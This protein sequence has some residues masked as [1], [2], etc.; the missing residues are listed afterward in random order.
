MQSPSYLGAFALATPPGI[1]IDAS[2]L[3]SHYSKATLAVRLLYRM[4]LPLAFPLP[5]LLYCFL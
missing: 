3:Y 5:L 1:H 2:L 4:F